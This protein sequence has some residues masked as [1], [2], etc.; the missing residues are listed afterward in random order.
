MRWAD[1]SDTEWDVQEAIKNIRRRRCWAWVENKE[2]IHYFVRKSA[3][4]LDLV[5]MF[6]HELGHMERPWHRSL[7]E[8][9]K[10]DKYACVASAAYCIADQEYKHIHGEYG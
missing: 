8:E 3:S 9:Q 10:A 2:F 5:K 1:G 7:K 6:A 4:V